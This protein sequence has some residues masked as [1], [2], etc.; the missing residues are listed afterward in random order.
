MR[1]FALLLVSFVLFTATTVADPATPTTND[2]SG[3]EMI[4]HDKRDMVFQKHENLRNVAWAE[5]ILWCGNGGTFNTM[6]QNEPRDSA[7]ETLF[8]KLDKTE[9][10]KEYQV[11][12]ASLNPDTGRKFWTCD[13][14]DLMQS[15]TVRSFH[16]LNARFSGEVEAGPDGK[17]RNLT[18][19]EIPL[20]MYKKLAFKRVS[21][22]V[23]KAGQPV[24]LLEDSNTGATW[25]NKAYQTGV[26]PTLT[27]EG[28]SQLDKHL[29]HL[30]EGWKF[31]TVVLK[32]D[33]VIKADGVQPIM[34][35][36]L[37]DAFDLLVPQYVNFM[38]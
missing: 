22:I 10:A 36:E 11:G 8:N 19:A 17:P 29:K 14:F 7:P 21:T 1:K 28:M 23:F 25:I 32:Q 13:E 27:Y 26:D 15:A 18:A 37:G 33:L 2:S 4:N 24:F 20:A 9:L 35:D 31:R 34:W 5:V 16:G 38:P 6:G 3:C 30:P 12:F